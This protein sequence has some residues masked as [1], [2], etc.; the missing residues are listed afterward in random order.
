MSYEDMTATNYPPIRTRIVGVDDSGNGSL[1]GPITA[2]AL[3]APAMLGRS[4][5]G[6]LTG[7]I[8]RG[9]QPATE[10][11]I[12]DS[13]L[14]R[15]GELR[16]AATW[17]RDTMGTLQGAFH[18][19]HVSAEERRAYGDRRATGMAMARAVRGLR[20]QL[21][22]SGDWPPDVLLV[23]GSTG[24]PGIALP[25]RRLVGADRQY[26]HVS[27]ASI[28]ATRARQAYMEDIG[29]GWRFGVHLG[30]ATEEHAAQI[31]STLAQGGTLH[32]EHIPANLRRV[33][34]SG[35]S[36]RLRSA[37]AG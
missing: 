23:D 17:L 6:H 19:G 18:I 8:L 1:A 26:W 36:A 35:A 16:R 28:L 13:K 15:R 34:G 32:P 10:V 20:E 5:H 37:V 24:I 14:L 12:S 4:P 33:V 25:Q 27:A 7:E 9:W 11:Q 2:C 31:R 29:G 22:P 3:Y 21:E 30:Y